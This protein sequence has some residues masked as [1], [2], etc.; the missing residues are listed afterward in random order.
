MLLLLVTRPTTPI[1]VVLLLLTVSLIVV[2]SLVAF[3]LGTFRYDL[4]KLDL[5]DVEKLV[6]IC[7]E[8][9]LF[10]K[11]LL[12][13]EQALVNFATYVSFLDQLVKTVDQLVPHEHFLL[14]HPQQHISFNRFRE[15]FVCFLGS[16]HD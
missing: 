6:A 13:V 1:P 2:D 7:A 14:R 8:T 3:P 15:S 4:F 5:G 10:V 16:F 9:D 12:S 11:I